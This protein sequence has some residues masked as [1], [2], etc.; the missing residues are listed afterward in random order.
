MSECAGAVSPGGEAAWIRSVP[1][2]GLPQLWHPPASRVLVHAGTHRL[3]CRGDAWGLG[4]FLCKCRGLLCRHHVARADW[5]GSGGRELPPAGSSAA[6]MVT[7]PS[8]QWHRQPGVPLRR[9]WAW[10][11]QLFLPAWA[12]LL[13]R[14]TWLWLLCRAAAQER[15]GPRAAEAHVSAALCCQSGLLSL[16]GRSF[17]N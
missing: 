15:P 16:V 11:V 12:L 8:S 7:V 4:C 10:P 9:P 14:P 1:P 5:A 2:T 6:L 13:P 3:P 17:Q